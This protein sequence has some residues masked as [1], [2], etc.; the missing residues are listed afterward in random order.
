M[1][2]W[3]W[4]IIPWG[5]RALLEIENWRSPVLDIFFRAI[6]EMGN[7]LFYIVF[8]TLLYWC[9]HKRVGLGVTL[10]YLTS[11]FFNNWLKDWFDIPRPDAAAI[12]AT[13]DSAGIAQRLDPL[14]R[15]TSPS[16]PSNHSQG[17]IVTWG[18][19]ALWAK[20]RWFWLLAAVL[21]ALIAF[22]R[23]Y[24]GV[25]FPQ[26]I[27]GGVLIG[28]VFLAAW[29]FLEGKTMPWLQSLSAGIRVA[30]AILLPV[31]A[32]A[33]VPTQ[34]SAMVMGTIA[35]MSSGYLVQE[36]KL[37]F[38]P[39]GPWGQRLLRAALGL[40]MVFAV[41]LGLSAL[42]KAA[43]GENAPAVVRA[44]RYALLGLTGS[45]AAPWAFLKL[46]LAEREA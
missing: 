35:G 19:L 33:L 8:L 32:F 16:F 20:Q 45:L 11:T 27:I 46:G 7:E 42:A 15:E 23:V 4:Q 13:L 25:H 22:S 5:Y 37:R 3:L 9:I 34:D 21:A 29:T 40:V 38:S 43:L 1:E 18:Y 30:V 10:A 39:A 6:T 14:L 31:L 26:D 17:A 44:A 36:E 2:D 12:S 41:Y 28:M 24:G